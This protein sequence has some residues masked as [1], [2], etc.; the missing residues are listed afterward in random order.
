MDARN[1]ELGSFFI[2]ASL[3]FYVIKN[4][5]TIVR[6]KLGPYLGQHMLRCLI[7][8][9]GN[10]LI[11]FNRETALRNI[12]NLTSLPES[13]I[14]QDFHYDKRAI[15]YEKGLITTAD[16]FQDFLKRHHC[17]ASMNDLIHAYSD[18]FYPNQPLID[19]LPRFKEQGLRLILLSNTNEAHFQHIERHYPFLKLFDAF[20]LS[21]EC[22]GMKPDEEI[23]R[24]ALRQA[25]CAPHECFYTD[26]IDLNVEGALKCGLK[27][28]P[29]TTNEAYCAQLKSHAIILNDLP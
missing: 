19:L 21:Y 9:L 2:F 20:T 5:Y 3:G 29:F 6:Q 1:L 27:A 12:V 11:F 22:H 7:F 18:M 8:D 4:I 13:V 28:A 26:D 24:C 10:V 17:Q 16:F 15:A 23:Y 14:I 25:G